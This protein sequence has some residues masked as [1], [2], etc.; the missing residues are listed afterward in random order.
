MEVFIPVFLKTA[1]AKIAVVSS[2]ADARGVPFSAG[3][4]SSKA[5]VSKLCEAARVQLKGTGIDIITIR[6]GFVRTKMTA[7][8]KGKMPFILDAEKAAKIIV[9][10]IRM[11]KKIISFPKVPAVFSY[12]MSRISN[13]LYEFAAHLWL[14]EK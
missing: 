10:K 13:K 8:F 12:I 7:N 14:K 3:Y 6:P 2:L 1:S 9:K 5:A 4:T 11:N